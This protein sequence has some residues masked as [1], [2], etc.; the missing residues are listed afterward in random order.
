MARR[1][2]WF[3][4]GFCGF[5]QALGGGGG[6]GGAGPASSVLSPE[7][8]RLGGGAEDEG[9]ADAGPAGDDGHAW[10]VRPSWSYSAFL[11]EGG[12]LLLSGSA[13]GGL[14]AGC[15]DLLG[16]ERHL[17]LLLEGPEGPEGP[18]ELQARAAGS[19][20][21]GEP[22]WRR[23][24]TPGPPTP[25]PPTP[26]PPPPL[27]PG[28]GHAS[29]RP[30]F[31]RPL[32]AGLR[33]R[34]LALGRRHALLLAHAGA[35]FAWGAGRHGQ[36][37]HGTLE[38]EREPRPVEALRGLP[39]AEV[40]A[41]GWHSLAVGESGDV[42]VWGWNES[43]QLALPCRAL[44]GK[45][46]PRPT[47]AA[48]GA[49]PGSIS[50]DVQKP[51]ADGDGDGDGDPFIAIQ[52]FPALLDLPREQEASKASCG[53]RHTAVVTRSGELY[54]WGWGKYG[55]LGHSDRASSDRARRVEYFVRHR[56]RVEEVTCGPWNTYVYAAGRGPPTSP[57]RPGAA[58][59][60]AEPR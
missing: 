2:G 20:L 35:L 4:F 18:G 24:L 38:S 33:A 22:L 9:E 29:P 60:P 28:P 3:G 48:E 41:G 15:R 50:H 51:A 39:V 54:T 37:G 57:S 7:P 14:P 52:P 1:S 5:G 56:L 23:A 17:V 11:G 47:Q 12:R 10:R 43:G 58:G 36:L 6:A 55:Q 13:S 8:L 26:A 27:L 19:G 21:R 32:A 16:S 25:G 44:S 42:Y 30:P 59:A 45:P 34:K 46:P 40:A 53:S 49:R 31:Y